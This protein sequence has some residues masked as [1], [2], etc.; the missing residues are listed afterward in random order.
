IHPRRQLVA[1][2]YRRFAGPVVYGFQTWDLDAEDQRRT[3]TGHDG[4]VDGLAFSPEGGLVATASRDG[5][6]RLWALDGGEQ[7]LAM[8]PRGD[9]PGVAFRRDGKARAV[10]GT[11]S[12][13]VYA[14]PAGELVGELKDHKGNVKA[15][16]YSPDG[17]HLASVALDGAVVLRDAQT[18]EI[19]G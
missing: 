14:L 12:V 1:A 18:N 7:V 2:S 16:G 9:P 4:E 17:R 19:V 5:T 6:V 11:R 15:V 8:R 10:S 13:F 3:Y